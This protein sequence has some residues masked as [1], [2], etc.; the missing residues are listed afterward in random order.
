MTAGH[1]MF[2]F[3]EIMGHFYTIGGLGLQYSDGDMIGECVGTSA[4]SLVLSLG[5]RK[6]WAMIIH[7]G[8]VV[9]AAGWTSTIER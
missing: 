7:V 3:K 5:K 1:L 4:V 6:A 2:E 8:E 9:H